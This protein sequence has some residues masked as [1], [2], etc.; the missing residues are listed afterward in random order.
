MSKGPKLGRNRLILFKKGSVNLC[1]S[2]RNAYTNLLYVF[3]MLKAINQ[4]IITLA[5]TT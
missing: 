3:K 2:S 4:L 1:V 5:I